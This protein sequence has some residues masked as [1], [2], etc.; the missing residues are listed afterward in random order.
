MQNI[1]ERL[2]GEEGVPF[3]CVARVL[4]CRDD[5]EKELDD[6]KM[7]F[8]MAAAAFKKSGIAIF[9][10]LKPINHSL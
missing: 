6:R 8:D 10:K 9:F 3:L 7:M 5:D 2:Q 1:K 4:Q